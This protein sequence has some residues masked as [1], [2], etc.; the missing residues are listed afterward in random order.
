MLMMML[1]MYDIKWVEDVWV[2][3]VVLLELLVEWVVMVC[4]L[5]EVSVLYC[6]VVFDVVIEYFVW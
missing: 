3:L 6:D 4:V 2:W 5:C 1:L